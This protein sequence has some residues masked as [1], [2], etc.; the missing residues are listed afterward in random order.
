MSE[1][2]SRLVSAGGL[3]LHVLERPGRGVPVVL[4]HG[5]TGSAA[6]MD[7]VA[8]RLAPEWPTVCIDLV[9]HGRSE[10]PDALEPYTMERCTDQL[11]EALHA[12]DATEC[13]L[14]GYSG[15]VPAR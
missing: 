1:P 15:L 9:G 11:L 2:R 6:C 13:H 14:F 3:Q 8:S 10:A 4:L 5:F 7:G 12:I